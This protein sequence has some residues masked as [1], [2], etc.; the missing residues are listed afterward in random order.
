[1]ALGSGWWLVVTGKSLIRFEEEEEDE[2]INFIHFRFIAQ[3]AHT[4]WQM[5]KVAIKP[6]Y[7]K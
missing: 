5:S 1:M 4:Y 7:S 6:S 3:T 2:E